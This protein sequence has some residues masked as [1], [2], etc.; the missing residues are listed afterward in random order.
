MIKIIPIL[1]V[2]FSYT[3]TAFAEF[4]VGAATFSL[5]PT[6]AQMK[7]ICLGGYLP[8]S[9]CGITHLQDPITVRALSL[10]DQDSHVVFVALDVIGIGDKL[11]KAIQAT[12]YQL[13][14]AAI[15]PE[16]IFI[17]ATHTHSGPDLQGLW[18]G[19]G[20]N[21]RQHVVTQSAAAIIAAWSNATPARIFAATTIAEVS[22]RRGWDSVDTSVNILD[23]RHT[24]SGERIATLVNMSAHPVIIDAQTRAYSSDYIHA[25]RQN[26]EQKHG[27]VTLF[28]NGIVGDA[29][30]RTVASTSDIEQAYAYG[31]MVSDKVDLILNQSVE[32]TGDLSIASVRFSHRINNFLIAL[33]AWVGLLDL[34]TRG[35]WN[36]SIPI[37][38]LSIGTSVQGILFP[39]EALS[40][41]G[42]AIKERMHSPFNYFFGLTGASYGYF[43]PLDEYRQIPGETNEEMLSL[44]PRV[45][46]HT[47]DTII[48]TWLTD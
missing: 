32:I 20:S 19:V 16:S 17:A 21:Y 12:T 29:S 39:G 47:L 37:S 23:F 25:L 7:T 14:N 6:T 36:V 43:L 33:L 46:G 18:G 13:S 11:I 35:F 22:N 5:N 44:S 3:S 31:A 4:Q 1:V 2:L 34:E 24:Q 48:N 10:S 26:I 30:P 38:L 9:R 27:G 41:L 15:A 28:F 42:L 45:G 8:F 40:R